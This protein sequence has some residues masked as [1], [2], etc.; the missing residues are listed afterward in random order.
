MNL[1][2]D[3]KE[4]LGMGLDHVVGVHW[5]IDLELLHRR[6]GHPGIEAMDLLC[7]DHWLRL[8]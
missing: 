3:H 5:A 7:M 8:A 1:Y 2:Y 6:L 4:E